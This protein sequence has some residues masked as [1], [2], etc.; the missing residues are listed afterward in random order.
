MATMITQHG[1]ESMIVLTNALLAHVTW[2]TLP[3]EH[4]H[5]VRRFGRRVLGR[6]PAE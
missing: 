3:D 4:R 6:K 2:R 5:L 1:M